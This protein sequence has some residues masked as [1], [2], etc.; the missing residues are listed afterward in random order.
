MSIIILIVLIYL[1]TVILSYGFVFAHLQ[2]FDL[3]RAKKDYI[4]DR[5]FSLRYSL[6]GPCALMYVYNNGFYKYGL[7]FW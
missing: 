7:K 1:V 6:K 5:N 3:G 4:S 2:Q